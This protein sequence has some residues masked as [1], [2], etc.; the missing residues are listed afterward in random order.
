[1]D[2]AEK[3][4]VCVKRLLYPFTPQNRLF[5]SFF[6]LDGDWYHP[7][8][9]LG[10][11]ATLLLKWAF[12]TIRLEPAPESPGGLVRHAGLGVAQESAFLL[13]ASGALRETNPQSSFADGKT[14]TQSRM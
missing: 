3:P 1:M 5:G 13:D 2:S 6:L 10:I 9:R 14:E 8:L 11:L 4:L 7:I 12:R